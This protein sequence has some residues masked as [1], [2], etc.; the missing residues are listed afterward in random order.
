MPS[1]I[2]GPFGSVNGDPLE[3]AAL[4]WRTLVSIIADGHRRSRG[5]VDFC[6]SLARADE[7][8]GCAAA[9]PEIMMLLPHR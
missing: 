1:L 5:W 8:Q 4:S 2:N 7:L 9:L 6:P 3:S